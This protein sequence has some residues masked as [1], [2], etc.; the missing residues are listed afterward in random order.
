M[1]DARNLL[2]DE[3]NE[4]SARDEKLALVFSGNAFRGEFEIRGAFAADRRERVY[5]YRLDEPAALDKAPRSG[6][7]VPKLLDAL[8]FK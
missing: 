7:G 4:I 1:H 3:R 8:P 2:V 5:V 6:A